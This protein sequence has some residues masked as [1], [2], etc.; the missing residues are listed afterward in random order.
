[1]SSGV[2]MSTTSRDRALVVSRVISNCK[3]NAPKARAASNEK[4]S[5]PLMLSFTRKKGALHIVS[6]YWLGP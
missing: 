3:R 4:G 6:G 5:S 2:F 1:M